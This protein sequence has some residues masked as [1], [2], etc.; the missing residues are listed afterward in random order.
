M[1]ILPSL[2]PLLGLVAT[3]LAGCSTPSAT[4]STASSTATNITV[5][6]HE[7]DKFTDARSSFNSTT[8][9]GYLDILT[10]HFKLKASEYVKPDQKL[11]ITVTDIDLAGDF[12]PGRPQAG[13]VRIVKD[14]Y[15]PRITLNFKL[16][17]ADGKVVKE[18]D[19]TLTDSYFM[20][21][22]TTVDRNEPLFYDKNMISD[23]MRDEFKS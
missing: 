2:L 23:W 22:V 15:R 5:N 11:E 18:G 13:D 10:R 9:L 6:Y 3:L 1:K 21:T 19:R 14:I 20:N 12:Q 17:G 8:D 4:S 7:P 16:T